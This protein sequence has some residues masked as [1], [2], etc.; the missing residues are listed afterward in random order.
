M[1]WVAGR[2]GE[3]EQRRAGGGSEALRRQRAETDIYK[4]K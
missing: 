4:N 3:A 1:G 2:G